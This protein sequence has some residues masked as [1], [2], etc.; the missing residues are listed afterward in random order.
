MDETP[1]TS[2]NLLNYPS[3]TANLPSP[4]ESKSVA[5]IQIAHDHEGILW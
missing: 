1:S 2:E 3:P 5:E 4:Y